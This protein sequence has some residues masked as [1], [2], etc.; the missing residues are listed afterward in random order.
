MQLFLAAARRQER[1]GL[2]L[3]FK[4]RTVVKAAVSFLGKNERA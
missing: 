2:G 1:I 3:I 4:A